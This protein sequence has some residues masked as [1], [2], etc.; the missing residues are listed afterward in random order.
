MAKVLFVWK[1]KWACVDIT[2]D[3]NRENKQQTI[4][5]RSMLGFIHWR[6]TVSDKYIPMLACT[7]LFYRMVLLFLF[8][9]IGRTR[10]AG[11]LRKNC[12]VSVRRIAVHIG[13]LLGLC[14]PLFWIGQYL[15]TD[16]QSQ[17]A[18]KGDTHGQTNPLVMVRPPGSTR[19]SFQRYIRST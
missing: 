6:E 15:N 9:R 11:S 8:F 18:I 14:C 5:A 3:S 2:I 10:S 12:G 1:L 7:L 13:E 17:W 16:T 19:W 4:A